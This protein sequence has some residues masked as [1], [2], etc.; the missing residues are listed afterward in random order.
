MHPQMAS[1]PM[2][3]SEA[4][5][6]WMA[7]R[8]PGA[9]LWAASAGAALHRMQWLG[10]GLRASG[11]NNTGLGSIFPRVVTRRPLHMLIG[12]RPTASTWG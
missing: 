3:H 9:A 8:E 2:G 7:R 11:L 1:A 4:S 12:K 6:L 5:L 10:G